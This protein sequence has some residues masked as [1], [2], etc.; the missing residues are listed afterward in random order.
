MLDSVVFYYQ[1]VLYIGFDGGFDFGEGVEYLFLV[2]W[3]GEEVDGVQIECFFVF[4]FV[5]Q[6]VYWNILGVGVCF[7]FFY[8]FLVVDI[9]QFDIENNGVGLVVMCVF[10]I[11]FIVVVDVVFQVIVCCQ[12]YQYIGEF[13][14]V[15]YYQN[16][17]FVDYVVVIIL[18][19]QWQIGGGVCF[20]VGVD[21]YWFCWCWLG[22]VFGLFVLFGVF[23]GQVEYEGGVGVGVVVVQVDFVVQ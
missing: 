1:Q 8:Y 10:Q 15:F 7:E 6:K 18:F 19:F 9:G 17:F 11:G 3:F 22:I 14:V 21:V 2:D 13:V 5:G 12:V 4:V 23:F 16:G 20:G